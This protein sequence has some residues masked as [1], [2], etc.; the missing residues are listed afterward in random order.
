M[1]TSFIV[2]AFTH[3]AFGGNPAAVC[4][5]DTEMFDEKMQLIAAEFN[6]SETAFLIRSGD[7]SWKLRWFTPTT[8]VNLCGHATLAS[9]HVLINECGL[10][11]EIFRFQT[12]SGELTAKAID[13]KIELNFPL[14]STYP[15]QDTEFFKSVESNFVSLHQAGEDLLMELPNEQAVRNYQPNLSA[16]EQLDCRGLMI[17]AASDASE[18]HFV[19]RFF[20]PRFGINEDPVTGSAHCALI[21]FWHK[22]TGRTHFI[23]RQVSKRQGILDI[24]LL[25]NRVTLRGN[26]VT[27]ANVQLR[28]D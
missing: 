6:L 8:E 26:S 28:V 9:A 10:T 1:I 24:E 22:E 25:D 2:D 15:L 3:K 18:F 5:L 12:R 7:D 19:S 20:G 17:T 14:T 4:L 16:I 21:D 13:Q 27:T 11:N 23:A